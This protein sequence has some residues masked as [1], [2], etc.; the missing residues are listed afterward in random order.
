[1]IKPQNLMGVEKALNHPVSTHTYVFQY[2]TEI[3]H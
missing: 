2:S 3:C 1:M